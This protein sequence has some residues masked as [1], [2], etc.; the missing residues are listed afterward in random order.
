MTLPERISYARSQKLSH[1][2]LLELILSDEIERRDQG[3][4]ERMN[5]PPLSRQL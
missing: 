2:E 4:I 5:L 3:T 1:E